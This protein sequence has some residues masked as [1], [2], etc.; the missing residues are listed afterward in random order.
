MMK[1]SRLYNFLNE[2]FQYVNKKV[3][4]AVTVGKSLIGF[5]DLVLVSLPFDMISQIQLGCSIVEQQ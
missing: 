1:F 5:S 2:L 3:L 4:G